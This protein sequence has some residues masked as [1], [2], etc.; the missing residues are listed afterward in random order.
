M[1]RWLILLLLLPWLPSL[2]IAE[3]FTLHKLPGRE[4][5]P[6]LL[7][8][9]GIHG[10]EPGGFNAAALL[11]TRYRIDKGTLWIVPDLNRTSIWKRAHG[12]HGDMN[13][14]FNGVET[15]DPD[16]RIVQKAKQLII[17]PQV[18]LI[19]NLHDGS[20]YYR[21]ERQSSRKNP[22]RWGQSCVIDQPELA[23]ATFGR[24]QQ[25]SQNATERINRQL[26]NPEHRFHVKNTNTA[27]ADKVMQKALTYFALRHN[28]P[29][30]A[31][32]ASKE[33]PTHQRVYYLLTALEAYFQE[34]G[35]GFE[36]DFSLTPAAVKQALTN[37]IRLQL[38]DGRIELALTNLRPLLTQFPLEKAQPT[39]YRA[40]NPL[41]SL[42]PAENRYRIYFGNN[43][44]S[45]LD[46]LY[47]EYDRSLSGID[48]ET[49]A[50]PTHASFGSM[51]TVK[52]SVLIKPHPGYRINLIGYHSEPKQDEAGQKISLHQLDR[53]YSIDNDGLIF[54]VEVYRQ[55]HFCG[56]ILVKYER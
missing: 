41:V 9:G 35:I 36:R 42:K 7:V 49:D 13:Y 32:E 18:E 10:D 4:P 2:A 17:D 20:G 39:N 31:L 1:L 23:G 44:L 24:M 33:L 38:G 53:N 11:M 12:W 48:L 6:T 28:K 34:V 16:Y 14:K 27:A 47:V 21:P 26:L 45:F 3:D 55:N 50:T 29:A 56:M 54:R 40:N 19:F 5:G 30:I 37:D 43:R 15:T 52:Q 8:I 51:I 46:P 25:L 22:Q